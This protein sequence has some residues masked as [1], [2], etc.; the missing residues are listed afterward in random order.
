VVELS[1]RGRLDSGSG[2]DRSSERHAWVNDDG[3]CRTGWVPALR[4][5]IDVELELLE[6]SMQRRPHG[7]LAGPFQLDEEI[8]LSLS[9]EQG[10]DARGIGKGTLESERVFGLQETRKDPVGFVDPGEGVPRIPERLDEHQ[11]NEIEK[12]Q[13]ALSRDIFPIGA[14]DWSVPATVPLV[15]ESPA[16]ELCR[17]GAEQPS[18]GRQGVKPS[19]EVFQRY[20][21]VEFPAEDTPILRFRTRPVPRTAIRDRGKSEAR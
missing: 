4:Q 11:F 5:L 21:R 13:C 8:F 20:L 16:A 15:A 9:L 18:G 2:N 19:V 6:V 7:E 12:G 3:G 17:A 1:N 10:I 14:D